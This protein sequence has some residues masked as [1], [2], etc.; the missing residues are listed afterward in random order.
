MEHGSNRNVTVGRQYSLTFL[1][2][3]L[4]HT[5]NDIL[6]DEILPWAM[7]DEQTLG[8]P[9]L[10]DGSSVIYPSNRQTHFFHCQEQM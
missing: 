10:T 1:T 9:K 8:H 6:H 5:E 7:N 2:L 3:S 4:S